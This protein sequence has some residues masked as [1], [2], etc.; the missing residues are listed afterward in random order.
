MFGDGCFLSYC[1]CEREAVMV[2]FAL[3]CCFESIQLRI[4][5]LYQPLAHYIIRSACGHMAESVCL[6]SLKF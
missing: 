4:L 5:G 6:F 1:I 3:P 2:A